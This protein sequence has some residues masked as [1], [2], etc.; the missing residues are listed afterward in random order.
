[1]FWR[2]KHRGTLAADPVKE[3]VKRKL[4]YYIALEHQQPLSEWQKGR[5][6]ALEMVW[7]IIINK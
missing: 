7:Q 3:Y 5:K 1:M 2:R 6:S 4:S